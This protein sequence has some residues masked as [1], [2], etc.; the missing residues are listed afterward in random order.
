[1]T[2][3]EDHL[4]ST[5]KQFDDLQE[6]IKNTKRTN[7]FAKYVIFQEYSK[8]HCLTLF[9]FI[10]RNQSVCK[11]FK[12]DSNEQ[13]D[14]V[15]SRLFQNVNPVEN[16][17]KEEPSYLHLIENR[18]SNETSTENLAHSELFPIDWS[19]AVRLRLLS[20]TQISGNALKTSQEASGL[21]WYTN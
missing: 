7:P 6:S 12:I 18:D 21:T 11:K 13:K 5:S 14:E 2:K 20:K 15:D 10:C 19:I 4:V 9:N 8:S 1:M 16:V 3:T 17:P